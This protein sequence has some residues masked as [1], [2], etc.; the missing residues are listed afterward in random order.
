MPRAKKMA[1]L[2]YEYLH[3]F[4]FGHTPTG[5]AE[6]DVAFERL[7]YASQPGTPVSLNLGFLVGEADR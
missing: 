2:M 7:A 3:P 5:L 6:Q 4:D 1:Q